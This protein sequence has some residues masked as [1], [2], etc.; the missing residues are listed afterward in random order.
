MNAAN[1]KKTKSAAGVLKLCA[2]TV[3]LITMLE[4]G[5]AAPMKAERIA[6]TS[7]D[8]MVTPRV[9]PVVPGGAVSAVFILPV[10]VGCVG[11]HPFHSPPNLL[12]TGLAVVQHRHEASLGPVPSQQHVPA[13]RVD[14]YPEI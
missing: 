7:S 13:S 10:W 11:N 12:E 8:L 2:I 9:S 1:T 14:Q 4:Y 5:T 6:P 3:P